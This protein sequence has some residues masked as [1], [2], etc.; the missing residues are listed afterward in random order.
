MML[1]T[2]MRNNLSKVTEQGNDSQDSNLGV[3]LQETGIHL[4]CYTTSLT[5]MKKHTTYFLSLK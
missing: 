1:E 2:D 4:L 5:Y 3:W